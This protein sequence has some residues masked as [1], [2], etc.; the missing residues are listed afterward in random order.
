[1]IRDA[2]ADAV[3]EARRTCMDKL[4]ERCGA[5]MVW[6]GDPRGYGRHG[7]EGHDANAARFCP[8]CFQ[9]HRREYMREYMKRRR[10]EEKGYGQ[11]SS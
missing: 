4:C 3:A 6:V 2:P 7:G 9:L 5:G 1:M 8:D 10:R 11:K